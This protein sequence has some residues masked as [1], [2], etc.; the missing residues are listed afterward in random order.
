MNEKT[1]SIIIKANDQASKTL[2]GVG[3]RVS[4]VAKKAGAAAITVTKFAGVALAGAMVL[5][6]K[7][8]WDQVGAVE[9]ATVG[10]KAYEKNADKVNMVLKD[11]IGYARSDMGVLFNRKDL[12]ESAQMLKLNGVAT[13]DLTGNVK[14]LSRSV[15]LGLGNWQDL[16]AVVGRV[17]STGRL[18]GIEFDQLTQYGFKLDKSLRNTNV[19]AKDLFKSLDKGIP[20]DAMAG[21]ANTIKGIGIRFETAFR[22]IG[23]TILGVDSD[24]GK[25]IEGGNGDKLRAV[26][27]SVTDALKTDQIK[28]FFGAIGT[29]I[30]TAFST[31]TSVISG[32]VEWIQKMRSGFIAVADW[33]IGMLGPSLSALWGT[34]TEKYNCENKV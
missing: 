8:S 21:Q 16:N 4:D 6:S 3:E 2:D 11:L 10:L 17:V 22:G 19:S 20:V 15:G 28:D 9:Q 14:I 32:A 13:E 5:A 31:A 26:I 24:T 12:F 34:I 29:G 33:V 25:F 18:S 7:A 1:L 27:Q 30:S 23:D